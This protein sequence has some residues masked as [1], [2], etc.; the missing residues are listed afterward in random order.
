LEFELR[1]SIPQT[2]EKIGEE[3]FKSIQNAKAR[4]LGKG[5]VSE[6]TLGKA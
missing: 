6:Q 4:P 5:R 1:I 2:F 3:S